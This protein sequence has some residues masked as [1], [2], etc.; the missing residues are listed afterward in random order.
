LRGKRI[1]KNNLQIPTKKIIFVILFISLFCLSAKKSNAAYLSSEQCAAGGGTCNW[2]SNN[3]NSD[4]TSIG[5]CQG[6]P[7][8]QGACCK[9][10]LQDTSG[11]DPDPIGAGIGEGGTLQ[12]PSAGLGGSAGG[13]VTPGTSGIP[14]TSSVAGGTSF[15]ARTGSTG[16]LVPCTDDCT[17]CHLVL[18]FK[19]I[20]DY[21]L[22]LLLVATTLV[23]VV[24]G[25][26]YMV[27]SGAKGMI[28][29]AKSA[30]TYALTAMILGLLA[31]LIINTVLNA[32]GYNKSGSWWTFTCDTTQTQGPTGGTGGGTLPETTGT[33]GKTG[34][35]SGG[36]ASATAQDV[37]KNYM[38]MDGKTYGAPFPPNAKLAGTGEGMNCGSTCREAWMEAGLPDFWNLQKQRWDGDPNSL[39][40]GDICLFDKSA[41]GID[42][43]FMI[44][45]QNGMT[46]A[47]GGSSNTIRTSANG[48]DYNISK[49]NGNSQG[50]YV[51]HIADYTK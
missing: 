1:N 14:T 12:N 8:S 42:H 19:N 38:A 4:Q 10:T 33:G 32:L 3:C 5:L 27:S 36:N 29:K 22:S 26:M 31:W 37:I 2:I 21:L 40:P 23:I 6:G 46:T 11:A 15:G 17:L 20:Y 30:F 13:T 16:G 45:D 49:L 25:V 39:K 48:L 7:T 51:F 41:T 24:A 43:A 34:Y 44:L 18:G 35:P 47:A 9:K 28:E 50:L